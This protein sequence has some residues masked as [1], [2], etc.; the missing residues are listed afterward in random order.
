[1]PRNHHL[2]KGRSLAYQSSAVRPLI[3]AQT[4]RFMYENPLMEMSRQEAANLLVVYD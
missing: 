3:S 4:V 1:M 2:T